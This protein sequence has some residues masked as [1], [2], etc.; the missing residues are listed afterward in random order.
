[1]RFESSARQLLLLTW[2][3]LAVIGCLMLI[4]A[5][6]VSV[7]STARAYASGEGFWSKAQK[8]AV[9]HLVRYAETGAEADYGRY[10]ENIAVNLGDRKARLALDRPD[11]DLETARQGLLAGRNHPDDIPGMVR[12]FRYFR[13]DPE[14]ERAIALWAQAD[15]LIERLTE[16]AQALRSEI[17]ARGPGSVRTGTLR[18]EIE[19]IDAELT[20]LEDGFAVALGAA[21]RR[22]ALFLMMAGALLS[23]ALIA[24]GIVISSRTLARLRSAQTQFGLV[25]DHVQTL[26]AVYDRGWRLRRANR[27]FIQT[28]GLDPSQAIG[29][30]L[31]ELADE[32]LF[33]HIGPYFEQA[34]AGKVVS[35]EREFQAPGRPT[36]QL[37]VTLA[38]AFDAEGGVEQVFAFGED[39]TERRHAEQALRASEARKAAVI[40]LALDCVISIDRASRVL[41]FNPAAEATF[42]YTREQ[43]LGRD[44]AELIIPPR[45]R[46]AHRKGMARYLETGDAN[47]LGRRVELRGMRSDR[48][49]F[50]VELSV[51]P[52]QI[53]GDLTFTAYLRDVSERKDHEQALA[54][55]AMRQG[56]VARFA[57]I[58]LAHTDPGTLMSE[59]VVEIAFGL[60]VGYCGIH[61]LMPEENRLLLRAQIGGRN[62]GANRV[63][64]AHDASTLAGVCLAA[65]Q[66]IV[67]RDIR[68]DTRFRERPPDM[69][70]EF[71]SAVAVPI[72]GP[73]APYGVLC[74]QGADVRDY[75]TE[76][77]GFLET[78][79]NALAVASNRH[80]TENRLAYFAQFDS[81]TGLP[82]RNL[83][84]DRLAHAISR[85][86]RGG[87]LVALLFIDLDRFKEINDSLGHE[88]GDQ[89]LREVGTRLGNGLR[90]GDTL[91]R[92]GGD[93]FTV[94]LED[95]DNAEQ[96]RTVA[97]KLQR[98]F[99]EPLRLGG[100]ELAVTPSIGIA[101]YPADGEDTDALLKHADIAMYH[102]KNEGRDNFQFYAADM[103]TAASER[104]SLEYSLR[105]ALEH[106]EFVLHYQPLIDL[107]DGTI[108]GAEA[109]LRWRHPEWGLV[110]PGRFIGI[111]E[112]TG[113]IVPIGEWVLREACS[114]LQQWRSADVRVVPVAVNLSAR[115]FRK[116]DLVEVVRSG[117]RDTGLDPSL[118]KLEIT[119]SLL[120]E[121]P[122]ASG[123]VLEALKNMGLSLVLD[124]FGTGY[125]SLAYLKHFPLDVLK[126]DRSFVKDIPNDADDVAIVRA[127]VGLA[128]SL[129]LQVTAEGVET[130]EQAA[131]LRGLGCE[132][133]QGYLFSKPIE[134]AAF[135]ALLKSESRFAGVG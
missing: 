3:L 119:E 11:P 50:P 14:I 40:E 6:G 76:E 120:M 83:F 98:A 49:E 23:L 41:E 22:I 26:V 43:A 91:A 94:I 31:N 80:R 103:S 82:N 132:Y 15:V 55:Q 85:A 4:A 97:E 128:H 48:S 71:L 108:A 73:D 8:Q 121:N 87:S 25:N 17:V 70:A 129:G 35:Y 95:L 100:R 53:G 24:A 104:R 110:P 29:M 124:D 20:P 33:R 57:Q 74:V 28:F 64:L 84:R 66:S 135:V 81:L 61:E 56:I 13:F 118:L 1:M 79:A 130:A 105:H 126:I 114:R 42:G 106:K 5:L 18:R 111:A 122:E 9:L 21:V 32:A 44:L 37:S 27:R 75:S 134:A 47:V 96:V 69:P 39:V 131:F 93:E 107:K 7:M 102:A 2:P 34:Y 65:R 112:Q 54:Q 46:S 78:I 60:G 51:S 115:Q 19:R 123:A 63:S 99:G 88:A 68:A 101:M 113:L 117:L 16:H 86:H 45:L 62:V 58:A 116:S 38:P 109:L 127:T 12:L 67:V 72:Q 92:L 90:E 89:V 77:I 52:V 59:T 133:A 30:H 125:S 10:L 36:V